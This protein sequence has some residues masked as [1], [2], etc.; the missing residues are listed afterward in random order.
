MRG[1]DVRQISRREF[2]RGSLA[3]AACLGLA[4]LSLDAFAKSEKLPN[5]AFILADDLGYQDVGCY[6]SPLIKTPNLDRMAS[7]GMRFTDYYAAA[8]VCTPSRAAL[9]TGCYPLRVSL[10]NVINHSSKIGISSDEITIAQLLK[11]RGY[12]TACIGKWHLGWQKQFLP[13]RHGF[14]YYFGLPYSNDMDPVDFRTPLFRNEEIIEQPVVQET[15]TERYTD[16][17]IKFIT[18]HKDG[19]FFLY[20]PHTF[21]H[22][23]LHASEKFSGKSKRGLY[24]DVV[25]TIDWST[26]RILNTLKELGLDENTLVIFSSDNGPWLSKGENGGCALP[27][28]GGKAQTWDGGMREPCIMRWPGHIPSGSTCS[29][30]ATMMDIYPTLAHFAGAKVPTDRII[31]GK[32]IRPLMTGEKDAKSPYDAFFYY[33]SEQLQAVR[34]GRWKLILEHKEPETKS[35]IPQS[36]Y[37]LKTD[38]GETTDV[39]AKH[40]KVVAMLLAMADRCREDLGDGITKVKGK[41]RRPCGRVD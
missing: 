20:L 16:E 17:A 25:E 21:P 8:P 40:P 26:G 13:T 33:R 41:N 32:D 11:T 24:G 4:G 10:P 15:L 29:E 38:I 28:R 30:V 31:D 7:E 19:P 27:L 39:S 1:I 35:T 9:M 14:D 18:K 3:G 6:G 22:V 12:S 2:L 34:S 37:D 5:F 36:L 23:P